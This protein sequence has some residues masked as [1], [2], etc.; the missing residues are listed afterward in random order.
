M[1]LSEGYINYLLKSESKIIFGL[2]INNFFKYWKK[3]PIHRRNQLHYFLHRVNSSK[4]LLGLLSFRHYV[5]CYKIS[6]LK[7]ARVR[8]GESK[9]YKGW[10]STNY[11]VFTRNFIDV[12]RGMKGVC[13]LEFVVADNVI[14]HLSQSSGR[15][16]I[17]NLFKGMLSGAKIRL[18]TPD[19]E[20]I[21][22]RYLLR[23][24]GDLKQYSKDLEQHELGI[25]YFPD[26]LRTTFNSFGHHKGF[27]YDFATLKEILEAV[28]FVDV[29][30]FRPGLSNT[31]E[32]LGVE[33][34]I[35]P[36]DGWSQ[37]CIEATKP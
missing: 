32:F 2:K 34:R 22:R 20:S 21:C 24:D 29:Q 3:I 4:I 9:A 12:T 26:I 10:V 14:E 30:L 18:A 5:T 27:I 16:M 11:Q 19:L 35:L 15:I 36:S 8:V 25:R 1:L 28:G 6:K 7:K 37:M 31:A 33:N 17:E 23:D 13:N